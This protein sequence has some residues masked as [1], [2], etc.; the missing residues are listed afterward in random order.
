MK[1]IIP[2]AQGSA[3]VTFP[4]WSVLLSAGWSYTIAGLGAVLVVMTIYNKSL[5]I[6]LNRRNM[7]RDEKD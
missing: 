1:E 2:L 4:A 3:L 5:E 7:R 6:K